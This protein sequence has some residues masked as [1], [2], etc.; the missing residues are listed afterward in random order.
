MKQFRI[1]LTEQQWIDLQNLIG[2]IPTKFGNPLVNL[3]I[4]NAQ[5]S[6]ELESPPVGG[7]AGAIQEKK[8]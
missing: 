6:Q 1:T 4:P 3:L 5:E 7:I 2:E 8:K